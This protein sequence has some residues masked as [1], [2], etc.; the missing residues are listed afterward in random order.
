ME[1][2]ELLVRPNQE[3][4]DM[5]PYTGAPVDPLIELKLDS[6][7]S[8]NPVPP[9]DIA[10]G[11]D[12]DWQP[13]R[14][15]R[16]WALEE[17]L[18]DLCG[19]DPARVVVTTG[20]DDGLERAF[21]AVC[22]PGRNAILT[23]PTFEIL[24]RYTRLAGASM[25]PVS[26]WSRDFPVDEVCARA[27]PDTAL[28]TVVTPNNP[29]GAVASRSAVET[30]ATRLPHA[31][32]LVDHAY[33]EYA[34]PEDD[35]T[36]LSLSFPNVLVFRTFSKA[37]AAAGLRV[38]YAVGDSRVV[39]WLR[40]LG[41]PYP[42]AA[43]SVSMVSRLLEGSSVPPQDKIERVR[44]HRTNFIELLKGLGVEVLPSRA[45][46]VLARFPTSA[47]VRRAL[48]CLGVGVRPFPG[49]GELEQWLRTTVP[50]DKDAYD[51][52]EAAFRTVLAPQAVLFD[53]DGV[54][55]DVSRSYREAI[56]QT[57]A[58]YD[59]D[60]TRTDISAAKAAGNANNDWELTRTLLA[61]RGVDAPLDEV[62]TRFEELYQG[63]PDRPGLHLEE[64][65]LAEPSLLRRLAND[66][67]LAVVTGRP[68]T[69]A[70]RFLT[71]HGIA[72]YFTAVVTMED[73]PAKPDPAPVRLALQVL[74]V[75]HAWMIGDTPDDLQSA[76]RAGVLPIGAIAPGDS[77]IAET[78]LTE[79]AA[80][81]I[82]NDVRQIQ[83][84]LP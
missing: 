49:R 1:E 68:R 51:R 80:A 16:T 47:W 67:P 58:S 27:T 42:V 9:L 23:V 31:L 20:A 73:A 62:T 64:T 2:R 53:L 18:S 30:L 72:D 45:N 40:T 8:L 46:F 12:R 10:F 21:R 55:A 15:M 24:E 28:V 61:D 63:T 36:S 19:V 59:V 54:L 44:R 4:A 3:V 13:N 75:D 79:A 82:I 35:L 6:N 41:Q 25:I 34:D 22:A 26:W 65:L 43:P 48:V 81:H 50:E 5:A 32:I 7:E 69:D 14:Y 38:G 77:G 33:V 84:I 52:L 56:R 37:W 60:L 78:V 70:E 29:T 66:R 76:R 71:H 11:D 39:R 17:R 57:A 83:E 74:G